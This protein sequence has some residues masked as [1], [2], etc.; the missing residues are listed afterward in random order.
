MSNKSTWILSLFLIIKYVNTK[1]KIIYFI[2]FSNV[3]VLF[4]ETRLNLYKVM[5][6]QVLLYGSE[7][8]TLK[9]GDLSRMQVSE[10]RHL[11]SIKGCTIAYKILNEGIR[12]EREIINLW[13]RVQAYCT[14]WKNFVQQMPVTRFP[15]AALDYIPKG[16]RTRGRPWKLWID[17][18]PPKKKKE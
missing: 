14:I 13:V 1:E 4:L 10:M 5:A 9:I 11:A 6:K 12:N 16:R 2:L 7:T 18:P 17:P 3:S 15:R 8:W